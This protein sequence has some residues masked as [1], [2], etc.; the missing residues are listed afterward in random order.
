[1]LNL[2]E[3]MERLDRIQRQL[4]DLGS[5]LRRGPLMLKSQDTSIKN[6]TLKL[7]Q[8]L[9]EQKQLLLASKA[10]E[11][12]NTESEQAIARRKAQLSESKNNKEF[13]ALKMQIAAD[14][15]AS[16]VLADEVLEAMEAY[17][18]FG[19]TVVATEKELE[20]AKELFE[21]TRKQVLAE[22]PSIKS[23]IERCTAELKAAESKLPKEFREVYDRLVRSSGGTEALAVIVNQNF[24][25]GCNQT[26]P[27]NSI[28]MVIQGKAVT[29]SSCGRLLFVP[30]GYQFSKG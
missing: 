13:Q 7:E 4:S 20:K 17:E 15:A 21:T 25:S 5:R 1:M 9:E 3:L 14:E 22:E 30:E 6:L 29:C 11:K 24:C 26:L 10:K 19:A 2:T 18:N 8:V 27:I 23:D 16:A 12:Q 28:A